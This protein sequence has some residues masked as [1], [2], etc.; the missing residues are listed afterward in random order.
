MGNYLNMLVA[1]WYPSTRRVRAAAN[2][3][4]GDTT[5]VG[6]DGGDLRSDTGQECLGKLLLSYG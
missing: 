1:G 6:H 5:E 2:K 3:W 4:P